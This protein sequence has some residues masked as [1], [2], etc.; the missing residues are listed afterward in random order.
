M[1]TSSQ[2]LGH[3]KTRNRNGKHRTQDCNEGQEDLESHDSSRTPLDI[4]QVK[5]KEVKKTWVLVG[6]SRSG[7]SISAY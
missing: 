5:S 7:H 1:K 3:S 6:V 4:S 2:L